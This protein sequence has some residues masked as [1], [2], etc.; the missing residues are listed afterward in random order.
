MQRGS[1]QHRK[2]YI[3]NLNQM[4]KRIDYLAEELS[5]RIITNVKTDTVVIEKVLRRHI[6]QWRDSVKVVYYGDSIYRTQ[7]FTA[8]IDTV[9]ND[10]DTLSVSY[11]YPQNTLSLLLRQCPDTIRTITVNTIQYQTKIEKRPI[12]LDALSPHRCVGS[13][14]RD[15]LHNR[16]LT[17]FLWKHYWRMPMEWYLFFAGATI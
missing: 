11:E 3:Y 16:T 8:S 7:S 15:W 5:G 17:C 2:R 4:A 9:L 6:I 10:C 13:R 12:W 1:Q 14:I